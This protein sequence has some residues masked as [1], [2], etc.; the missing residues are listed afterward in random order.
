MTDA[1]SF[2]SAATM[3]PSRANVIAFMFLLPV[4]LVTVLPHG[5]IWGQLQ[6]ADGAS[7]LLILGVLVAS[8]V[9]HELLHG[10]GYAAGEATWRDVEFGVKWKALT[11][12]AHCKTTLRASSYRFAVALPALVLGTVP[13]T[14]GLATG[15]GWL[16]V[17]AAFMLFTAGGDFA[18]LW[19]IRHV[20]GPAWVQDH[21]H[22][23]GALVLNDGSSASPPAVSVDALETKSEA[24]TPSRT[25]ILFI[26]ALIF[27]LCAVL[28]FV[29]AWM[30]ST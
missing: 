18:V 23:I 12:Y 2:P 6:L 26:G 27:A 9:V 16:T 15:S 24:D 22:D 19:A 5:L 3:S 7:P 29:G 14:A 4:L 17:Y 13:A 20:P 1:Q 28:G 21:P 10:V 25:K 8:I 11:P 30:A